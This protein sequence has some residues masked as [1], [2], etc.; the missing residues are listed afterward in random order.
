MSRQLAIAFLVLVVVAGCGRG[1]APSQPLKPAP[2]HDPGVFLAAFGI[3]VESNPE[4]FEVTIPAA[5][6]V[7]LGTYPEG[8]YWGI[9]SEFSKDAGLDITRLKGRRVTVNR[10]PI[11]GGLP[12]AGEQSSFSYPSDAVVLIADGQVAG[13]W[14]AFNKW[15]IGP[16]VKQRSLE[17]IT[18]LTFQQWVDQQGYFQD[19]GPNADLAQLG[20][21]EVLAAFLDAVSR[22]DKRRAYACL[23]PAT[24]RDALT[25]NLMPG[26]LY[27]PGFSSHN[28][29]VENIVKGKLLDYE[30]VEPDSPWGDIADVGERTRVELAARVEIT[31]RMPEF[32]TPSGQTTRFALMEKG[33][34]GWKLGGLGTGP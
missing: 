6:E 30:M 15:G 27:N 33:A 16:S 1:M 3:K 26:R 2:G 20:P 28:S 4:A 7:P 10:Y 8:L 34:H 14:L 12:G 13:A 24:L 31:W 5:W 25:V 19:P 21:A 11:A 17:Q 18:G 22:G 23:T 29:L 32:N 9:V